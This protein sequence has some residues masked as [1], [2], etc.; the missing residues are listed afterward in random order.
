MH[1]DASDVHFLL[2]LL[3]LL[4]ACQFLPV[5]QIFTKSTRSCSLQQQQAHITIT[6]TTT[7]RITTK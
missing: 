7:T 4:L 1:D 5:Q 2:L 6:T 3:L